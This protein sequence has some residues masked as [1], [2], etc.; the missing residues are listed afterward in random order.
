[1]ELDNVRFDAFIS[2]R[3]SKTDLFIAKSIQKKL[4]SFKLPKSVLP[5][6]TSGKT[7]IER[8]FRDQ[9]E[10]PLADN[11]SDSINI[12][13]GNS[14][15]LIV[16]CTPRLPES[17]WCL[18]EIT[19]FLQTHQRDHILLVLAEGEPNESFP[20]ELTHEEYTVTCPDGSTLRQIRE[21]EPL[22]ADVRGK[23]SHEISSLLN[24]AT[25]RLAAA[26]LDLNYDDLKQRHRERMLKRRL[27]IAGSIAAG[28][29]AFGMVAF[30]M[31]L[32]INS[33]KQIISEQYTEIEEKLNTI[34]NQKQ[35][36]SDQ[37]NEIQVKYADSMS[38]SSDKLLGEGRRKDA[39]Y[40]LINSIGDDNQIYD[41]LESGL[42]DGLGIYT[43]PD[44]YIPDNF[45]EIG[46]VPSDFVLSPEGKKIAL[47]G[48]DNII[49]IFDTST[50]NLL[51]TIEL[52]DGNSSYQTTSM[53]FCDENILF[54]CDNVTLYSFNF[55]TGK[56]TEVADYI[57][58]LVN[59]SGQQLPYCLICKDGSIVAYD[60]KC[61]EAYRIKLA[62]EEDE[63]YFSPFIYV[64]SLSVSPNSDDALLIYTA[65]GKT[66]NAAI[67]NY[68]NG[69]I[70]LTVPIEDSVST[71][72]AIDKSAFYIFYSNIE[73]GKYSHLCSY[74]IET[75]EK[76]YDYIFGNILCKEM[77]LV[78]NYMMIR[79][80]NHLMYLDKDFGQ[81]YLDVQIPENITKVAYLNDKN[82][83]CFMVTG[84]IYDFL[85]DSNTYVD[86]TL[87]LFSKKPEFHVMDVKI[88]S[89]S[90][91]ILGENTKGIVKYSFSPYG[92]P[93]SKD[94]I[95]ESCLEMAGTRID[96][97]N[98]YVLDA[99]ISDDGKYI[100]REMNDKT[101]T[102]SDASSNEIK[103]TIYDIS[104]SIYDFRYFEDIDSYVIS[105][106]AFSYLLDQ[107]FKVRCKL[108]QLLACENHEMTVKFA[109]KYYK[110]NYYTKEAVAEMA[111]DYLGDYKPSEEILTK[112]GIK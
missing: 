80:N 60:S 94:S 67:F 81:L 39:L 101:L 5:K 42:V 76:N 55:S 56:K 3:H 49:S 41:S 109:S 85:V 23:S 40:A 10:L 38:V 106:Y 8:I 48:S 33:Q 44:V 7:G 27:A 108:P 65:D 77:D 96:D 112:Y 105:G 95:P 84:T 28:M 82:I 37:Y 2:Y 20:Y 47:K 64:Y 30:G 36:I 13:L 6:I 50:G 52:E 70:R 93:I 103:S 59:D 22:A 87:N 35:T 11:L 90:V 9:D 34:E 75:A 104:A 100:V 71:I 4:E 89:D 110:L 72:A 21:I 57:S 86:Y 69:E 102:I 12:A 78:N 31:M 111:R 91:Y 97:N 19:T 88:T 63:E 98:A 46:K 74:S 62:T 29:F 26:I 15:Y 25:I 24:D 53:Y 58:F 43:S 73:S 16:I 14:D 17:K 61:T 45:F 51:T 99:I 68:R 1:M 18:K 92:Y 107:N 83:I 66:P 54:F 32:K 79:T